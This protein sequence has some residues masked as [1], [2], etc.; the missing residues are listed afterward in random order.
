MLLIGGAK[1]SGAA[2]MVYMLTR[3]LMG[4][5]GTINGKR[6]RRLEQPSEPQAVAGG[7]PIDTTM[8]PQ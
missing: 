7:P 1:L 2:G 6:R 8:P 3:V 4:V 5:H